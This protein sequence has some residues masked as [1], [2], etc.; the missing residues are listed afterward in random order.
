MQS[1]QQLLNNS[2]FLEIV[3]VKQLTWLYQML[4]LRNMF[5]HSKPAQTATSDTSTYARLVA[6]SN[7]LYVAAVFLLNIKGL[8]M[9]HECKTQY[10]KNL[11]VCNQTIC[12]APTQTYLITDISDAKIHIP[13]Y[14]VL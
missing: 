5:Q 6:T 1:R 9:S 11:M 10:M 3:D 2:L 12:I 8:I 13:K 7:T 4:S 14:I